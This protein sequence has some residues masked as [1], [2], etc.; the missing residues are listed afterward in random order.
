MLGKAVT[1]NI[2]VF[3]EKRGVFQVRPDEVTQVLPMDRFFWL[4]TKISK[5][6]YLTGV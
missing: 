4:V 1:M 2:T 6:R 5:R 3:E